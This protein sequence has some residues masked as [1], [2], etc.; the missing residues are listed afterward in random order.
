QYD[1]QQATGGTIACRCGTTFRAEAPGARDADV[2]RCASCG[3]LL[4]GDAETCVYCRAVVVRQQAPAGPV[5]PQCYAR[6]PEGA[7]HC[8]SCGVAFQPQ[9]VRDRT[10]P[11][12]CPVCAPPVG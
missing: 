5:C 4:G 9:P 7:R 1:A 2:T 11:L 8:T 6:N 12:S 10:E 3:A